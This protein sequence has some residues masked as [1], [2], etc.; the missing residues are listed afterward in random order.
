M[1][2]DDDHVKAAHQTDEDDRDPPARAPKAAGK[3]LTASVT[4]DIPAVIA[5]GFDEATRRDPDHARDWIA[6]VD[7][8]CA[9]RRSVISP[10][11]WG[12][13]GGR[14]LDPMADPAPKGNIG[15]NSMPGN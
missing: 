15:D 10:T 11:E 13:I 1:A 3:W 9:M 14:S 5:A 12:E 8:N 4:D 7:G 6:L 2:H